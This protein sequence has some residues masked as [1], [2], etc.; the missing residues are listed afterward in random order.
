MYWCRLF[1]IDD[2]DSHN[3]G[4]MSKLNDKLI[5]MKQKA[6]KES[7]LVHY[8]LNY[9]LLSSLQLACE[10]TDILCATQNVDKTLYRGRRAYCLCGMT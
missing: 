9:I 7:G 4:E 3:S 8:N 2:Y 5:W 6:E 10:M 1:K